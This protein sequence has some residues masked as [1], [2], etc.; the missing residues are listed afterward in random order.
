MIVIVAFS[1]LISL[2]IFGILKKHKGLS[3]KKRLSLI[4]LHIFTLVFPLVFYLLFKGCQRII[5]SCNKIEQVAYLLLLTAGASSSI[6]LMS[7][8][9]IFLNRYKKI[10]TRIEGSYLSELIRR[11]SSRLHIKSPYL[12]LMDTAKPF[13]FSLRYKKA[14]IFLSIGL[15]ELLNK[16]EVEAVL[17]HELSHIK[18]KSSLYK[19]SINLFR[20]I[21]PLAKFTTFHKELDEEELKADK[22]AIKIQGT[23][24]YISSAKKKINQFYCGSD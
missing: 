16:K 22:F 9:F 17:L 10:S 5:Y 6:G 11:H 2:I 13:T 1:I 4:Y 3:M 21:S 19:L 15:M 12:Y 20:F 18:N 23:A 8:P 7:A 14:S 24:K